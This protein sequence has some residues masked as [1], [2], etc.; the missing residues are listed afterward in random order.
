[1]YCI[2]PIVAPRR[3]LGASGAWFALLL[4]AA[5]TLP[6]QAQTAAKAK[7]AAAPAAQ[8]PPAV[9]RNL[10]EFKKLAALR[11]LAAN[12]DVT[13]KGKPQQ[14]LFGIPILEIELNDDATVKNISVV[15]PPA[16]DAAAG[17][18]DIAMEAIKKA[19]PYGDISRLPKPVKWTEV[20]LFNDQKKFKPRSLD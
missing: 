18:V 6:A 17:T 14:M 20:F 13:Y 4:A 9:A 8:K 7:P 11:M 2:E 15:R 12:P 19:A 1:V 10:E 5:V 3:T 16:N